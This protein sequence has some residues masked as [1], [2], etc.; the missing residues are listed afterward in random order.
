[1]IS[2]KL[3]ELSRIADVITVIRDGKMI[4]TI[5]RDKEAVNEDRIIK[6]MVGRE[7]QNRYPGR[8]RN[9]GEVV[10]EVND[11]NVYHPQ[12]A[13]RKVI[14]NVSLNVRKGEVV[15]L[16]GL[17]GAGR[18]EL[19]MSIFGR[20]YGQKITGTILKNG[21]PINVHT[22]T[23]AVSNGLAYVTED[24]KQYGLILIDDVKNNMTLSSL[25]TFSTRGVLN[26]NEEILAAEEYKKKINVKANSI[27]Q[28]VGSLSGGNQQK[29]VLAKWILTNPDV[30]ILDEPTRGIDVGAKYEIYCVINQLIAEGKSI[31]LISS[32][33]PEILGMADRVY[34]VNEGEIAGELPIAEAT[35]ESIMKCIMSHQKEA[36]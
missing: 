26:K 13:S 9:I 7:L 18:T 1:M 22:I 10:F 30:L 4:E 14:H 27:E 28:V 36:K 6:G 17:M 25:K 19:A 29:V 16:A 23:N 2:H 12:E 33:L 21:S 3:N 31:I 24:R 35:Q 15:G 5:D 34:V 8:E 11:W 20:S 32:E